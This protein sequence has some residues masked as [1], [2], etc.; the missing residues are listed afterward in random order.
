MSEGLSLLISHIDNVVVGIRRWVEVMQEI[1]DIPPV[2]KQI[3]DDLST[4]GEGGESGQ[5]GGV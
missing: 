4:K 1:G 5:E 2:F 3:L